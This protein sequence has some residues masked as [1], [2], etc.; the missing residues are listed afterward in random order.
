MEFSSLPTSIDVTLYRYNYIDNQLWARIYNELDYIQIDQDSII[1]HTSLLIELIQ[2][3]YDPMLKKIG[4]VGTDFLHKEANTIYFLVMILQNMQNLMYIKFT[5]SNQKKYSRMI[6]NSEEK[7]I[8][9]DFKVLTVTFRLSEFYTKRELH[10]LNKYL[11]KYK[12][13]DE[14]IPFATHRLNDF[15]DAI[16]DILLKEGDNSSEAGDLLAGMLDIIETKI[17]NDNPTVL[18]VTDY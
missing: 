11:E 17:E 14:N 5:R 6:D 1:V 2:K 12:L 18:V 15:L 16:D 10:I 4:S 9:F 3:Y 13:L 8:R 7:M